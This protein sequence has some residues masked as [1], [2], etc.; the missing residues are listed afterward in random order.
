MRQHFEISHGP[1]SIRIAWDN[2]KVPKDNA[3][4][5]CLVLFWILWAPL[6]LFVTSF[7]VYG[8]I[9]GLAKI[10]DVLFLGCWL[11]FGWLGT[12]AIPASFLSRRAS[13]W[14]EITPGEITIGL[15]GW[16]AAVVAAQ[17]YE[18]RTVPET[19]RRNPWP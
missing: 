14:V 2:R 15:H 4:A 5:G 9:A 6:T 13:E 1:D 12:L 11:T 10:S 17:A 7:L 3:T 16:R 19:Y 18:T 8:L